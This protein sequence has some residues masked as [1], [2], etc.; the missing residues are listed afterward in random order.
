M[1]NAWLFGRNPKEGSSNQPCVKEYKECIEEVKK[2]YPDL[3][4]GAINQLAMQRFTRR[5]SEKGKDQLKN[6]VEKRSSAPN[7]LNKCLSKFRLGKASSDP[8]ML[9]G[10][11]KPDPLGGMSSL[12]LRKNISVCDEL[13]Q[14]E[15]VDIDDSVHYRSLAD[16]LTNIEFESSLYHI[17]QPSTRLSEVLS[18]TLS[19]YEEGSAASEYEDLLSVASVEIDTLH[20]NSEV[21]RSSSDPGEINA[22]QI[23]RKDLQSLSSQLED[24]KATL[25]ALNPQNRKRLSLLPRKVKPSLEDSITSFTSCD[26][27]NF[28]GDFSAW[29]RSSRASF[30]SS[31]RSSRRDSCWSV[32]SSDSFRASVGDFSAW[33]SSSRRSLTQN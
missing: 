25:G 7:V 32:S 8:F 24:A 26:E 27:R 12:P 17:R 19:E 21:R 6:N 20:A 22:F 1:S 11:T 18:E 15:S 29:R 28:T 16:S 23:E 31:F 14:I 4:T 5:S 3:A 13:G 9:S 2:E 10:A 30:R 33:K